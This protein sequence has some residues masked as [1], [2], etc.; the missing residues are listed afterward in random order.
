MGSCRPRGCLLAAAMFGLLCAS[1]GFAGPAEP[2]PKPP[3]VKVHEGKCWIW[4]AR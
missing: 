2:A 1:T 3:V 4:Y